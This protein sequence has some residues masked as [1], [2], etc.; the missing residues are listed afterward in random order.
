MATVEKR[1]FCRVCEPACGLIAEV[2]NDTLK[3]L[4]PDKDH[5]TTQGFACQKGIYGLDIHNDPDRLNVPLRRTAA[6]TFEATSWD[7]A[8]SDIT[9]RLQAILDKHGPGAVAAYRG[10]PSAFNAL[11]GPAWGG[12]FQALGVNKHFSSGTQDCTNKFAGSEAVFGTRTLHPIPDIDHADLILLFGENPAVSHMSFFS[13]A[14]PMARLRAAAERGA[15]ILYVNPREIES[16]RFAGEVLKIRPDTDVYLLAALLHVIDREHGFDSEAVARHGRGVD[17]LRDFLAAYPP[18]RVAPVTGIPAETIRALARDF[19][20]S[21]R[22]AAHMSTGVNMGRQGTLAYW[23]LHMLVFLTGNLGREGGNFYSLGFYQRS[24]AS[25]RARPETAAVVE[26]R[27]G[28]MRTPGGVGINYP[29]NLLAD[30]I[31]DPDEPIRALFVNAGNP[32]LSMGGGPRLRRALEGLELLVVVDI[33]RNN[34]GE[35][36]HYVLPA[37]DAFERED[38]NILGIGMQDKPSVQ[39]TDAMVSAKYERKP[40]W[41]IYGRLLQAMGKPSILDE[42]DSPNLWGRVDAMLR[43][44]GH[45]MDEL[46]EKEVIT[47]EPA[48]RDDFYTDIIQTPDRRVDCFP[49]SFDEARARMETIFQELAQEPAGGLKLITKRDSNMMNSW[50]ANVARTK[51]KE[52]D[53]NY[54]YMN[55]EDAGVRQLADGA[56]VEV[57]NAFGRLEIDLKLSDDLLP[58]VVAMTHGWGHSDAPGMQV[59][60]ATPGVNANVLLPN[61]PNSFEPISNQAHMT[62]IPVDVRLAPVRASQAPSR[63]RA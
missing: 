30:F 34:T 53:R 36:A 61:G 54:L 9:A 13:I 11:F 14:A 38:V 29:G 56:R 5:P 6:G 18:E 57:S 28:P 45:S 10:N 44:R 24:P 1:T 62:G 51:R 47:L 4:R 60:Q 27:Y 52:R 21:K 40:E 41:W 35:L 17:A 39:Y 23:L 2:E 12:F 16:A 59:A 19:A 55:P 63:S 46:K 33:Y 50:Y 25:G 31:T 48:Q 26:T 58:G 7:A 3:A 22:A 15:R 20:G 8:V 37:A 42:G 43:S 32:L 49:A